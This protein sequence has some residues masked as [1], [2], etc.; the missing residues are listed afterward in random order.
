[1]HTSADG[2][3]QDVSH[4]SKP[5]DTGR[6]TFQQPH[7]RATQPP[8]YIPQ[9]T[10]HAHQS[11]LYVR[12]DEKLIIIV[13]HFPG[14]EQLQLLHNQHQQQ[15]ANDQRL[16]PDEQRFLSSGQLLPSSEQRC[17][18]VRSVYLLVASF[19]PLV[20]RVC[21]P[22]NNGSIP[23]MCRSINLLVREFIHTH[24]SWLKHMALLTVYKMW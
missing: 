22:V 2:Q 17:L 16:S 7:P 15:N 14:S 6:T 4:M 5:R 9:L 21:P 20:Y 12:A 19:V 1:M 23:T 11:F 3:Q 13:D 24:H 10:L 8:P 18:P